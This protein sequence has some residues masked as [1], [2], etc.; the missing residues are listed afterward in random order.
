MTLQELLAE[1]ASD[2]TASDLADN[3][4]FLEYLRTPINKLAALNAT[5]A[6]RDGIRALV[7]TPKFSRITPKFRPTAAKRPLMPKVAAWGGVRNE[8]TIASKALADYVEAM[9]VEPKRKWWI[10]P[11]NDPVADH[12]RLVGRSAPSKYTRAAQT[13]HDINNKT[14]LVDKYRRAGKQVDAIK[15]NPIKGAIAAAMAPTF[16]NKTTAEIAGDWINRGVEKRDALAAK[17]KGFDGK[18]ALMYGGAA[19]GGGY[20]AKKVLD[21]KRAEKELAA[22]AAAVEQPFING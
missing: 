3:A 12:M 21:K 19:V 17:T 15:A 9:G 14:G 6:A 5:R 7:R 10:G 1:T 11:K 22:Q 8:A 2:Y 13:I 16:G 18:K 20:I 4:K